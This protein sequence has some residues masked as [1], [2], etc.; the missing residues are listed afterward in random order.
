MLGGSLLKKAEMVLEREYPTDRQALR[1]AAL[2][3]WR[4]YFSC[5]QWPPEVRRDADVV[6]AR[7]FEWGTPAQTISR[8]DDRAVWTAS[9][10]LE[11][12][13]WRYANALSGGSSAKAGLDPICS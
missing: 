12:F 5:D 1:T 3:F 9:I 7:I 11:D 13:C 2:L 10:L 8:M 6:I 4:A